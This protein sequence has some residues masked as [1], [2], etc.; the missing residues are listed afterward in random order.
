MSN[1][2]VI[3]AYRRAEFLAVH[4]ERLLLCPELPKYGVLFCVDKGF[5]EEVLNVVHT[6]Q[7]F[8]A[9]TDVIVRHT[10]KSALPATGNIMQAYLDAAYYTD[11]FV[12]VGEEDIFPSLDYLRF[13][14]QAMGYLR[15]YDKI[16]CVAHKRRSENHLKGSPNILIGDKQCTSPFLI[17]KRAINKYIRPL[18]ETKG[19]LENPVQFNAQFYPGSRIPP[20]EHYDHDGQIER[21]IEKNDLWALKPD[22]A[23]TMHAGFYGGPDAAKG[24]KLTGTLRERIDQLRAIVLDPVKLQEMT[25]D[26]TDTSWIDLENSNYDWEH[27]YLAIHRDEARASSWHYD[28]DNRF[29]EYINT[30][31]TSS[32]TYSPETSKSANFISSF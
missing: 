5:S 14:E 12:I 28:P 3:T 27:L 7:E 9:N 10:R 8:H 4:L 1:V 13:C 25:T 31:A 32:S 24:K 26:S 20:N 19:Y 16:F 29:K 18:V 23:R 22:Q 30:C 6:F 21:I 15:V 2:I 11:E 17:T